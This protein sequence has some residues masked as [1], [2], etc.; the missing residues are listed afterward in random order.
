[1]AVH[2]KCHLIFEAFFQNGFVSLD[3][4]VTLLVGLGPVGDVGSVPVGADPVGADPV[5]LGSLDRLR[6]ARKNG[7]SNV[8]KIT[9]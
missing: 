6:Q 5:R 1:M 8:N 9:M 2:L 7:K 3:A 4:L